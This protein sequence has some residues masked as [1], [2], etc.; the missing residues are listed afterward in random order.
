MLYYILGAVALLVIGLFVKAALSPNT[1]RVERSVVIHGTPQAIF[2]I[3]NDFHQSVH[4]S[5]WEKKDLNMKQTISG[6]ATGKGAIHEW[7]GN[8]DV[9]QGREEIIESIPHSKIGIQLD[10]FRPFQGRNFAEFWLE[11]QGTSTKMTW[12]IHGPL[13]FIVRLLCL[14]MDKMIGQDFEAGL[15]NLKEYVE[16]SRV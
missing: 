8:K 13:N 6:P 11:P 3:L 5:P 14:N 12:L 1:F 16:G 9:G 2:A 4:W 7:D 10:F 15:A